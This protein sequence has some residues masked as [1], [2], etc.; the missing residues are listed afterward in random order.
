MPD[1]R[2][3]ILQ[4]LPALNAGGVERGTLEIAAAQAEAGFRPLVASAGGR[5]VAELEALGAT[6]VSLPLDRKSPLALWRNAAALRAVIREHGVRIVHARSR[7]PAWSAL[8][9]ARREGV[10]FV[11]TYH[12]SY[13]ENF[14][15]KRAYNAVMARG[16]RVVA[17]SHYIAELIRERH[18]TDPARIRIIPRGVDMRRFDPEAVSPARV[19]ALRHAWNL[20]AGRPV[21]LL[22]G[23]ISRW[24]GQGVLLQALARLPAPRPFAILAGDAGRGRYAAELRQQVVSLG[25]RDDVALPGHCEDLPAAFLLADLAL[26][27]STDAEAF[28]RTIVEAQAMRCPVIASDLGAPRETVEEGRT[29]WRVPPGDAAALAAAIARAL[30]LPAAERVAIG[31]QARAAVQRNYTTRAMQDA[32]LAVYRELL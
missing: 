8:L 30:A 27:C 14:P 18:G 26:H 9:A 11:T 4:V 32:T 21:L 19:E 13:N 31:E 10:R 24:K 28:G 23:R 29:G 12:G 16:D 6:H 17:I 22:S 15:G 1:T 2:P 25:L 20:P 5:M 7:A 3:A